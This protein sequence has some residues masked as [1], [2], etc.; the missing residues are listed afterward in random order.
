MF[1]NYF[2]TQCS[3]K[4]LDRHS[5]FYK[6][7]YKSYQSDFIQMMP[8]SELLSVVI[9]QQ[10]NSLSSF[11]NY[12]GNFMAFDKIHLLSQI[13]SQKL[14]LFEICFTLVDTFLTYV[15]TPKIKVRCL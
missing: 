13:S 6:L 8:K 4:N 2:C 14:T 12:K 10:N 5:N 9:K 15:D 7:G 3:G 11:K 1:S